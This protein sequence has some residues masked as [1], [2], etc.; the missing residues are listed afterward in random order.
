MAGSEGLPSTQCVLAL[1][2]DA[3]VVV[4]AGIMRLLATFQ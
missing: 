4:F 1:S 2:I 3:M